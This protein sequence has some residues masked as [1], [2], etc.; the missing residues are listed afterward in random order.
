M[1]EVQELSYG[2][3]NNNAPNKPTNLFISKVNKENGGMDIYQLPYGPLGSRTLVMTSTKSSDWKPVLTDEGKKLTTDYQKFLLT[4]V[5]K[6]ADNQRAA[7]INNNF[8][9]VQKETVFK[10]IPKVNNLAAP[11]EAAQ[12]GAQEGG[13]QKGNTSASEFNQEGL[14][15]SISDSGVRQNYDHYRY[16][17]NAN[18]SQQDCIKFSMYRYTPKKFGVN[19]NLGGFTGSNISDKNSPMGTVTLP[20]Q[21]SISDSNVVQWGENPMNAL[22]AAAGAAALA[23]ILKGPEGLGQSA[24]EIS[25]GIRQN[26]GDLAAGLAAHFASQAAGA[27]TGFLTRATGA[28]L[29]NNLELL[30]QGPSL[31]SFTFN[32]SLSAREQPEAEMI[33]KIIRLFKQGMSVKRSSSALFLKTPNIFDIQYLHK[34][35]EHRYINQIKTC[36]LQSCVVNYTPA[37]NYATYEDGA[38]TQYDLTLTFGEIEPLFD[39]DYSKSDDGK[40]GY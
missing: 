16:P 21:P 37:G 1:A 40:I 28:V 19:N 24:D 25:Q 14:N 10:G 33:R 3:T 20:I 18:F 5:S 38:M 13:E 32:F 39:D 2:V 30:F 12:Q 29:N 27:N 4:D 7:Y 6:E 36:A 17:I 15:K 35:I 31:R 34:G 11:S 8:T 9:R 22:E 26:K 23:G